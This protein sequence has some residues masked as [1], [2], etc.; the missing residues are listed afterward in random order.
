M[1][2]PA[3]YGHF[4]QRWPRPKLTHV[5]LTT[6]CKTLGMNVFVTFCWLYILL[7]F[8]VNDQIDA[9]FFSCIYFNSLHVS[10]NLVLIIR[11]IN[12]INTTSSICHSV[13]GRFVCR[14]ESNSEIGYDECHWRTVGTLAS[15]RACYCAQTLAPIRLFYWRVFHDF[16]QFFSTDTAPN[17]RAREISSTAFLNIHSNTRN[18]PKKQ[19]F[20]FVKWVPHRLEVQNTSKLLANMKIKFLAETRCSLSITDSKW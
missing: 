9:P 1:H 12:C 18:I 3:T 19:I 20:Q 16:S 14:S 11:R 13:G 2:D 7:W 8:L 10:S 6:S 15:Y 4:V 17:T 5:T